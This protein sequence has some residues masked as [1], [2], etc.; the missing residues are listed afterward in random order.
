MKKVLR[1]CYSRKVI[2]FVQPTILIVIKRIFLIR[3]LILSIQTSLRT[4]AKKKNVGLKGDEVKE[5]YQAHRL[6]S[7]N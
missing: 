7:G 3:F 4:K 5:T 1:H 2:Q 6:V